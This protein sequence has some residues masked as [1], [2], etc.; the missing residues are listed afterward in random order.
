MAS[1]PPSSQSLKTWT[2]LY[3]KTIRLRS[4]L[5]IKLLVANWLLQN[6]ARKL[7]NNWNPGTK[8]HLKVLTESYSMNINMTGF[9]WFPKLFAFLYIFENHLNPVML[10]FSGYLSLSTRIYWVPMCQGVSRISG[11]LHHFVMAKLATSSIRVKSAHKIEK[12]YE[13]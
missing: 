10:V 11:F 13:I 8:V 1:P 3:S 4:L 2:P 7:K 12:H 5:T 9:R 6:Y